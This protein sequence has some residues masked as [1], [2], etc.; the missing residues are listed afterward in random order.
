MTTKQQDETLRFFKEFAQKWHDKAIN[1]DRCALNVIKQRNDYVLHVIKNRLTTKTAL[2]V[3]CGA[4]DLVCDLARMGID[5]V[6]VDFAPEMIDI[7][8]AQARQDHL[9]QAQFHCASIFDFELEENKYDCISANGFIEYISLEE[10]DKFFDLSY[11]ALQPGGA[12]VVGSRNRLFNVFS[13]NQFTRDEVAQG[14]ALLLLQEAIAVAAGVSFSELGAMESAPLQEVNATHPDT[15]IAVSTR[16]QFTPAQL[17]KILTGKGFIIQELYPIHIHAAPPG[18]TQKNRE[19]HQSISQLLQ[20]YAFENV[21]LVPF[22][23][24]F[25]LHAEKER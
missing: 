12:L 5:A 17:I 8:R 3:G 23:S 15:G 9:A 19:V 10:M 20:N 4:G 22:A 2:D 1:K 25:M 21:S 7:A 6:G 13:L 11:R 14:T 18:F 24:S 16:Y